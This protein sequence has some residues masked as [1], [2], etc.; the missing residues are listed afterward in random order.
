M[1]R[2]RKLGVGILLVAGGCWGWYLSAETPG[3]EGIFQP[4]PAEENCPISVGEVRA[5]LAP[6]VAAAQQGGLPSPGWSGQSGFFELALSRFAGELPGETLNALLY[7]AQAHW[8]LL[9]TEEKALL[10][11]LFHPPLPDAHYAAE[12]YEMFFPQG[13]GADVAEFSLALDRG[14]E[15][16]EAWLP[17]ED[18]PGARLASAKVRIIFTS[19]PP[20]AARVLTGYTIPAA[21]GPAVVVVDTELPRWL[22]VSELLYQ[23]LYARFEARAPEAGPW[24]YEAAALWLL[25]KA[26]H[27][28]YV[29]RLVPPTVETFSRG[30]A[31]YSL[32]HPSDASFL[33]YLD[34]GMR[35]PDLVEAV[36]W[37][38][39]EGEAVLEVVEYALAEHAGLT[40]DEVLPRFS[41][42]TLHR[43]GRSTEETF[44]EG[45]R[46]PDVAFAEEEKT[47]LPVL[48][49]EGGR[50]LAPLG[51]HFLRLDAGA[52][53][54]GGIEAAFEASRT[55]RWA[56]QAL[57]N[58]GGRPDEWL[59]LGVAEGEGRLLVPMRGGQ[60]VL[61][62]VVLLD[63]P[64]GGVFPAYSLS[65]ERRPH[66]PVEMEEA[67]VVH[68]NRSG[69]EVA[70]STAS[71]ENMFGWHLWLRTPSGERRRVTSFIIPSPGTTEEG[72]HYRYVSRLP[73]KWGTYVYTL[74]AVTRNG[75]SQE[76]LA[77]SV[78][79]YPS[80]APPR[81]RSHR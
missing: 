2:L 38:V 43:G 26:G 56:V 54:R 1:A 39:A 51:M 6:Y 25:H 76:F 64:E 70:W 68:Q 50:D 9:S 49:T 13:M 4:L 62:A 66:Y 12:H 24:F 45:F 20:D 36:L 46:W 73:R 17:P 29:E 52:L 47:P 74:E 55:G 11:P 35:R 61:F 32:F 80:T 67:T 42:W 69:V 58:G 78:S 14:L 71:E 65:I 28:D 79:V 18:A 16:V 59:S 5:F 15:A 63:A 60:E 30:L 40:L 77:G 75:L 72:M 34:E 27:E 22:L 3:T 48:M 7:A 37:L 81:R 23:T 53:T 10:H 44:P 41:L 8:P 21:G 19:F 31:S 33:F 57:V